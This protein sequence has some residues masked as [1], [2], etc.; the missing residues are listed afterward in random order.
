MVEDAVA[1]LSPPPPPPPPPPRPPRVEAHAED[2]L[3]LVTKGDAEEERA[4]RDFERILI[5]STPLEQRNVDELSDVFAYFDTDRD[6]H[7]SVDQ[8]QLA[9]RAAAVLY[10]KRDLFQKN[11]LSRQEWMRLCG[12]Y[13]KDESINLFPKDKWVKMFR[14]MDTRRRGLLKTEELHAFL[15]TTG[16]GATKKQVCV[17]VESINRYGVGECVTE[18]EFV[19][20]MLK[21][22]SMREAAGRHLHEENNDGGNNSDS[23][24]DVAEAFGLF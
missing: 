5:A 6:G 21:R 22:Q 3:H 20:F 4:A 1:A 8:A 2:A 17:L 18:D 15:K 11:R 16:L 13:A 19:A 14:A 9:F 7:L 12:S 24:V 23:T 10:E